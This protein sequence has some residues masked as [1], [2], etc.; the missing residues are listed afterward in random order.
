[1]YNKEE[2]IQET[3]R[4]IKIVMGIVN[5]PYELIFINDGSTDNCAQMIEEYSYW[6]GSVKLI[7][8]S[9]NFGI[10]ATSGSLTVRSAI[11]S[12]VCR[13]KTVLAGA[14]K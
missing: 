1:M 6:D 8:L 3:Y 13:R 2:V 12:S 11:S 7:E 10:P 9:R 4:R 5:E 14:S